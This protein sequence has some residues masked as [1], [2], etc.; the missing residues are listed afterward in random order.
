MTVYINGEEVSREPLR[1][2]MVEK[3]ISI[4]PYIQTQY[5]GI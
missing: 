2:E 5:K 3:T 1:A 4:T